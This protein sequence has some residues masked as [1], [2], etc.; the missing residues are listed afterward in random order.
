MTRTA[1]RSPSF[2]PG[3][4][5]DGRYLVR[6]ELGRGGMG[7]VFRV[8]DRVSGGELALKRL[9]VP[10]RRGWKNALL[11][12]RREFHTVAGLEHPAIVRVHDFGVDD[13]GPYYTMEL[14]EGGDLVQRGLIELGPSC[15]V[16]RDVA[17]ALAFLNARGLLHRDLSMR[18]VHID[19][20]GAAK[21]I[22]FGVL[23]TVGVSGELV[24]TAPYVS[25]EA[26]MGLPLDHRADLY[27][28]G[29]LAYRFLTARHAYPA[30]TFDE[31]PK[32]WREPPPPPS[33]FR[34]E[35]SPALDELVL[36]LLGRDPLARPASAAEVI[37][38]LEQ[39]GGIEP[40][41]ERD[42][43]RGWLRSA[44][45][46]GRDDE[47]APV[48]RALSRLG[49]TGQGRVLL[50]EGASG[51]G[52]SRLLQEAGLE[53]QVVGATVLRI[54]A[55]AGEHAP[56]ALLRSLTRRL[57]AACEV[58]ALE[59]ARPWLGIIGRALPE[60]AGSVALEKPLG[61]PGED[62]MRLQEALCAWLRALCGRRP[63][64]LTIDDLEQADEGSAA[65]LAALAHAAPSTALT[66]VAALRSGDTPRAPAAVAAIRDAAV[67]IRLRGL[68]RVEVS[69]LVRALFG[70]MADAERIAEWMHAR[71][72][73]SPLYSTELA[74]HLVERSVV[75][76]T[77][78]SWALSGDLDAVDVPAALG[79]ALRARVQQLS[80]KA[81]A[82]AE[83][84]A[85]HGAEA[86]LELCVQLCATGEEAVF[87]ALVELGRE[88]IVLG[89]DRWRLRH[90]GLREALLASMDPA[91]RRELHLRA[92]EVLGAIGDG[93]AETEIARG[94][95]AFHGGDE[96]RAAELLERAGRA[97]YETHSF[98]DAVAP[99]AAALTVLEKS[100]A[101]RRRC[102]EL[103][104]MLTRAGVICDRDVVLRYSDDTIAELRDATGMALATRL[105][106]YL[107]RL[108]AVL[109]GLVWATLRRPF[110]P[111]ARRPPPTL[112]ALVSFI[113][114][115]SYTA[116]VRSLGFE[117]GRLE[118][119][120]KMLEPLAAFR[121][122]VPE[123]A[124]RLVENF[125]YIPLGR[126]DDVRRNV[127]RALAAL[128]GDKLT[129]LAAIDRR[130]A[131][132][133]ALYMIASVAAL[134]QDPAYEDHLTRLDG[135]GLRF[136]SMGARMDRAFYHR[137]RGEEEQA[138]TLL[139]DA[140]SAYVQLGSAWIFES[141]LA[142]ISSIAYGLNRDV[143]GLKN[144]LVR[145]ERLVRQGYDLAV[146]VEL[147]RGEYLRERGDLEGSRSALGKA[148]EGLRADDL[149][150]AQIA[151]GALAETELAAGDQDAAAASARRGLLIG[152][153][154][155]VRFTAAYARCGRALALAEAGSGDAATAA[156]RLDELIEASASRPSPSVSGALHEARARVALLAGDQPTYLHHA[157]RADDLF[158]GTKNPALVARCERLDIAFHA[159]RSASE[160][161]TAVAADAV[162]VVERSDPGSRVSHTLARCRGGGERLERALE[163]LVDETFGLRGY[164]FVPGRAAGGG[165]DEPPGEPRLCAPAFGPEPPPE[166]LDR[167]REAFDRDGPVTERTDPVSF[168]PREAPAPLALV[169]LSVAA[170]PGRRLLG[171]CAIVPGPLPMRAPDGRVVEQI[172]RSLHEA[173]DLT[174]SPPSR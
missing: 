65:M 38:R 32:L 129:P 23:A 54:A 74:R 135:L 111:A 122:R 42:V 137:L 165:G 174:T 85:V 112:D 100:G 127:G 171:L 28:L 173:G 95:H 51:M 161:R 150:R 30:R 60:L 140:E 99:L 44:A 15:R 88:E 35:V 41:P 138:N 109:V 132:G 103:R 154:P 40:L 21:L 117:L 13:D 45:L 158:R 16:L 17:S 39:I 72:G 139:D 2:R 64:C 142:W 152:A 124:Y 61:D 166:L 130:M 8:E 59:A 57:L 36:G 31:L 80:E 136:F 81:R 126:W 146:F 120:V 77:A 98:H 18:N 83:A 156:R 116:S 53:G 70:E 67:R 159:L 121:R 9:M 113:A 143:L 11:H 155:G 96:Q 90:D 114:L 26:V 6:A 160:R 55:R 10:E 119:L 133:G 91:R 102:L 134:D 12:F 163:L 62:R 20:A 144:A 56:Y 58:D 101:P 86:G 46:I 164:L 105:R 162:T 73:G 47:M 4:L 123:G 93:D 3:E 14:L 43:A 52:K 50:I 172:A 92:A 141:Q 63:L 24:G 157:R 167:V 7:A 151:H 125:L 25:P 82:L 169:R 48:R 148:L 118:G 19:A 89:A 108:L 145:L 87:D 29:A 1:E 27:A 37:D 94:W 33:T 75:R 22:D 104:H 97:L 49:L 71:A 110:M 107:G 79:D 168:D 115:V 106:P 78:G 66:M 5:V 128:E 149:F 76:Y 84:L 131:T 69:R 147:A 34:P 68:G 153:D 170:P